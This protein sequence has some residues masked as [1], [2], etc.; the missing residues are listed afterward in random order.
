VVLNGSA[1]PDTA[2]K[3]NMIA[4]IGMG[5]AMLITMFYPMDNSSNNYLWIVGGLILG[6]C[7]RLIQQPKK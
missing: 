3:G 1:S 4:G 7:D 6:G 2:K 5:A